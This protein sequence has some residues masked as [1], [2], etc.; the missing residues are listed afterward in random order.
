MILLDASGLV[1]AID[2]SERNHARLADFVRGTTD[3]LILSPFVL[4]EVDYLVARHAGLD[5]ELALLDEVSRG[6]Y[7][8]AQ[9]A[10]EELA[11][12]RAVIVRYRDLGIGLADASIVVLAGKLRTNRVLTLDERHFRTLR[13][14]DRKPFELLPADA[15]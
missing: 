4:A 2:Q 7:E 13:T 11:D 3:R 10:G 1:A 9:F 12:A 8:L 15:A 14:P 5:A 6:T